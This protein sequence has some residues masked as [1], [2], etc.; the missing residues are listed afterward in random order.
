MYFMEPMVSLKDLNDKYRNRVTSQAYY[1]VILINPK[2]P[3]KAT[4][5]II[6]NL[7]I[8]NE[9]SA[10]YCDFFLPGFLNDDQENKVVFSDEFFLSQE[11]L[12]YEVE[13][14][15][16][17]R[18]LM[19]NDKAFLSCVKELRKCS[20][21]W[22]YK[23]DAELILIKKGDKSLDYSDMLFYNLE[24]VIRNGYTVSQ[25]I[26]SIINLPLND[27]DPRDVKGKIDKLYRELIIPNANNCDEEFE[28]IT[29]ESFE[30]WHKEHEKY[31][32]ISYASRDFYMVEKIVRI[33]QNNGIDTWIAPNDIPSGSSYAYVIEKAIE[34]A[35]SFFLAFSKNSIKSVWVEKEVEGIVE[36]FGR[37]NQNR[38][39]VSY[40]NDAFDFTKDSTYKY[41]FRNIQISHTIKD[42]QSVLSI[43]NEIIKLNKLGAPKFSRG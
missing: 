8:Y 33:F 5:E 4:R 11:M 36:T 6:N 12:T 27:I 2:N 14:N 35:D 19:F 16:V 21:T 32:F 34:N 15:G 26:H 20:S 31:T 28:H 37:E 18:K 41:L 1:Y 17:S 24:D 42:E 3:T 22:K 43:A 25:L 10:D 29:L 13:I 7:Y 9:L 38:I 23:G 40:L 39:F 30:K